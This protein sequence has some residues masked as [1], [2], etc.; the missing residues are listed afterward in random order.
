MPMVTYRSVCMTMTILLMR[1]KHKKT[2]T[3]K[4]HANDLN[5]H[6][7]GNKKIN[8]NSKIRTRPRQNCDKNKFSNYLTKIYVFLLAF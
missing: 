7:Q 6:L 1:S 3:S 8:R 4:V 5:D 2:A